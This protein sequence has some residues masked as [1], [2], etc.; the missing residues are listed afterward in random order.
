MCCEDRM[1][2]TRA[3]PTITGENFKMDDWHFGHRYAQGCHKGAVHF[4]EFKKEIGRANLRDDEAV[5]IGVIQR[6]KAVWK[7][8]STR[9]AQTCTSRWFRLRGRG[10][11]QRP[12]KQDLAA[13]L[14]LIVEKPQYK[15]GSLYKDGSQG[16]PASKSMIASNQKLERQAAMK[17]DTV[18]SMVA[19]KGKYLKL[20]FEDPFPGLPKPPLTGAKVLAGYDRLDHHDPIHMHIEM[21]KKAGWSETEIEKIFTEDEEWFTDTMPPELK[22]ILSRREQVVEDLDTPNHNGDGEDDEDDGDDFNFT[23]R[24]LADASAHTRHTLSPRLH[25]S[26]DMAPIVKWPWHGCK[27]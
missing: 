24:E 17:Q 8:S 16:V 13:T 11:L 23:R 7:W 22:D 5:K 20:G 26:W 21:L 4:P 25:N 12:E 27:R 3:I 19:L 1:V 6:I 9:I 10:Q 14:D 15:Y 18:L 2:V